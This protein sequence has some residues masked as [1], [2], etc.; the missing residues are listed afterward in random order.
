MVPRK[1][2]TL[3]ASVYAVSGLPWIVSYPV[4]LKRSWL[5]PPVTIILL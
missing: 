2:F 3:V 5:C 1:A 4:P